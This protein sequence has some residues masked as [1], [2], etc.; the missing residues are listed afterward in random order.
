MPKVKLQYKKPWLPIAAQVQKLKDRGLVIGDTKETEPSL[1]PNA[2]TF[3]VYLY[4]PRIPQL[5]APPLR[6]PRRVCYNFNQQAR[7]MDFGSLFRRVFYA[8]ET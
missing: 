3:C 8:D 2:R 5:V 1:P 4:N 7:R 6:P